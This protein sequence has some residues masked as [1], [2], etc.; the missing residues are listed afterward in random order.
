MKISDAIADFDTGY[1]ADGT[2]KVVSLKFI[3]KDGVEHFVPNG[4]KCGSN[5]PNMQIYHL[6]GIQPVKVYPDGKIVNLSSVKTFR[7]YL[8]T[9]YDNHKGLKGE[10]SL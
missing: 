6:R 8:L 3:A 1:N 4:V 2:K 5:V 10:V 9:Y 7:W